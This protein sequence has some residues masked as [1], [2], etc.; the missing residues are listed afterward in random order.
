M[1]ERALELSGAEG[2]C[3]ACC[4]RA[5]IAGDTLSAGR[6]DCRHPVRLAALGAQV[7][8]NGYYLGDYVPC[9]LYRNGVAYAYIPF[10][11]KVNIVQR[12]A[13]YRCSGEPY[14]LKLGG[15]G[16]NSGPAYLNGNVKQ[17]SILLLRWELVRNRPFRPAGKLA[18]PY[19]RS[20]IVSFYNNAV[21]VA[22]QAVALLAYFLYCRDYIRRAAQTFAERNNAEAERYE[23]VE[24]VAVTVKAAVACL[25][26]EDIYIESAL[27]C[28]A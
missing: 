25:N 22:R 11:D 17:M 28:N 15:R 16:Q 26:I 10:G 9:L 27:G 19:A 21:D 23:P 5:H 8:T 1:Y 24:T 7:V 2:I 14:R 20:N 18:Y 4:N 12:C 3:A 13:R 6:A